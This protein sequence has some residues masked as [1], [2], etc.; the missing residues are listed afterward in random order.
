MQLPYAAISQGRGNLFPLAPRRPA[1]RFNFVGVLADYHQLSGAV[2]EAAA[3]AGA[4]QGAGTLIRTAALGRFP[5]GA[6]LDRSGDGGWTSGENSTPGLA[7]E[8]RL[9]FKPPII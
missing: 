4:E 2:T 8:H 7:A 9:A 5:Q 6:R 1:R 3:P